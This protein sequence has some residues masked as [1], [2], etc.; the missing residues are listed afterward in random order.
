MDED[1]KI[2]T[3]QKVKN[4]NRVEAGKRV[5]AISKEAKARKA[6]ERKKKRKKNHASGTQTYSM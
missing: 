5:G 4:P 3:V 1:P 2:T 6:A